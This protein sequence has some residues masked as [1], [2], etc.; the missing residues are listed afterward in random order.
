MQLEKKAA[1]IAENRTDFIPTPKW[2]SRRLAVLTH[3]LK[4]DMV[5]ISKRCHHDENVAIRDQ[6][7]DSWR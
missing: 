7:R 4:I 2:G 6:R 1:C 3:W 5:M